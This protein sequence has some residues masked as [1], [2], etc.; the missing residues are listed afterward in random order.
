MSLAG[1]WRSEVLA[2][3][4]LSVH[5]A[6]LVAG[7]NAAARCAQCHPA[8]N[9]SLAAWT[10]GAAVAASPGAASQTAHCMACH[11][12]S[13]PREFATAAHNV[14]LAALRALS[15]A[16]EAASHARRDPAVAIACAACH[17]EHQGRRHDL[18]AIADAA[19]QACHRE[20]FDSFA[21]GHP[22]FGAWPYLR[23]TA[24]A[25]D[26]AAHQ[27]KHHPAAKLAFACGDCHEADATRGFQLTRSYAASCAACHDKPLAL[28]LADGVPLVALPTLDLAALDG[29]GRHVEGW[30]HDADGDFDGKLPAVAA[31]LLAAKPPAEAA[32]EKLGARLDFY[33][34]DP[35]D[36]AQLAAA[37]TLAVEL[38]SLVDD[39]AARGDAAL[40]ERLQAILGRAPTAAELD[41]ALA[42]LPPALLADYRDRWFADGARDAAA[43]GAW[44]RDDATLSL[45]YKPAGH[46]DP[47]L[48]GWLD[49]L[50]SAAT[51]PRAAV[52]EPL[53]R[54]AL[55]PTAPGQCGSCHSVERDAA[56]RLAIPWR[57]REPG[58]EFPG[59]TR[60]SHAPHLLQDALRDCSACHA[61]AP[62]S[63]AADATDDPR[64]F[65]ADFAP[66][67]TAACT[68]CHTPSA[69]GS[70][71]TQCHAYHGGSGQ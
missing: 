48:R 42:K 1:G 58:G 53:L 10:G 46:A 20:P 5:H 37:A 11:E 36:P 61:I 29:A 34:I 57:P 55:R 23:R 62:H 35:D 69:A 18:A 59:L 24:I 64:Q 9:A 25:F 65:V 70:S 33:D 38:K 4:P 6:H 14:P 21:A 71:C 67:T 52:A 68:A 19:C 50:A 43:I 27:A 22:E 32:L 60:F 54:A 12:K 66:L 51:G 41:A 2:P 16:Q 17:Q 30:P 7:A 56:G 63:P 31:L 26:H 44:S 49:L 3:G 8:A 13:L 39:L 47:W 28:S 45:R 15:P 40:A